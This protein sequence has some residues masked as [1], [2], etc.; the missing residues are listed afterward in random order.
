MKVI[1]GA[2]IDVSTKEPPNKSH[3]YCSIL[4]YPNFIWT[5][6]TAWASQETLQ[7]AI[8]QLI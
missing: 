1:S 7:G 6:H 2:G 4:K 5:P 3:P 8:N